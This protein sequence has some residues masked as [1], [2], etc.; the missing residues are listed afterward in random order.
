MG[1]LSVVDRIMRV[2]KVSDRLFL[3]YFD[4]VLWVRFDLGGKDEVVYGKGC[5]PYGFSL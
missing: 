3:S 2:D 4:S 1:L 5:G